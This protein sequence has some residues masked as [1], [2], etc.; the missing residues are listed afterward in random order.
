MEE[1]QSTEV[2]EREMLDD[3]RKKAARI[4]QTAQQTIKTQDEHWEK[5]TKDAIYELEK[6]YNEQI[7]NET[8]NIMAHLPVDKYRI[9]IEKIESLLKDAVESWYLS[10]EREKIIKLLYDELVKRYFY[11]KDQ[12]NEN[13]E[14]QIETGGLDQNEVET[15]LKLLNETLQP[16]NNFTLLTPHPSPLTQHSVYPSIILESGGLRIISSIE[17]TID[18]ILHEKR[19][20]L[21][22]ALTGSDFT[23]NK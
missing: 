1:L 23:E 5:K 16:K 15:I 2:L 22:E 17:K 10:L 11:C 12:I 4:L 8:K 18:F 20:E 3:A 6:K 21:I 9:K 14:I 13:E 19:E 7:E